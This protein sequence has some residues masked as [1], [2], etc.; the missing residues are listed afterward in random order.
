MKNKKKNL[1]FISNLEHSFPRIPGLAVNL[2]KRGWNIYLITPYISKKRLLNL[3]LP[4]KFYE[5][6]K[7]IFTKPYNDIYEP[8]RKLLIK[9]KISKEKQQNGFRNDLI[10]YSPYSYKIS[11]KVVTYL[12]HLYQTMF[13]FPDTEK[14][15]EKNAIKTI[16]KLLEKNLDFTLISSSPYPISHCIARHFK[17]KYN[18]KWVAD[19]RDPWSQN[20]NYKMYFFRKLIDKL[21]EKKILKDAN[22]ITTPTRGFKQKLSK[23]H[24]SHIVVIPNGYLDINSSQKIKRQ[25]KILNIVYTGRIYEEKQDIMPFL[26]GL[27]LLSVQKPTIFDKVLVSFYGPFSSLLQSKIIELNFQKIVLQK[28]IQN[29]SKIYQ[30]QK[31]ADI[32]MLFNWSTNESGIIPLKLYEYLIA[33][34]PI[35]VTG[36]DFEGEISNIIKRTKTGFIVEN[37]LSFYKSIINFFN[38]FEKGKIDHLADKKIIKEYSYSSASNKLDKFLNSL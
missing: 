2:L 6:V 17:K 23:L 34:R 4:N 3:G 10:K 11:G 26:N 22:L 30:I 31:E 35:L 12:L 7:I 19:F 28:G 25:N 38:K 27:K 36:K 9:L 13:A 1:I 16:E 37:E 14:H 32:L 8:I 20:H 18:L 33:N 29:R 5:K 24:N 21:Y 15:W